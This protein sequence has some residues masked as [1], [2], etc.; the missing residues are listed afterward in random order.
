VAHR[1]FE[2]DG[3]L[4]G[5]RTDSVEFA[6]W[7]EQSLPAKLVHDEI[8]NPN[9][10]AL[11]G[12][13]GRLGKWLHVLYRDSTVLVRTTDANELV[14]V[15]AGD[16][17]ALT[18]WRRRDAVYVQAAVVS[19]GG[20][21][22]LFPEEFIGLL[23]TARRRIRSGGIPLPV[24]RH[25]AVDLD[26]AEVGL[27]SRPLEIAEHAV[28]ELACEVG[29][30]PMAWPRVATL[31]RATPDLVCVKG[32]G[33][34]ERAQPV[35]RGSALYALASNAVNLDEVRGAGLEAL[36]RLVERAACWALPALSA[37]RVADGV[38]DLLQT[39]AADRAANG[40]YRR[41][42]MVSTS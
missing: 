28:A 40:R 29:S 4:F 22:A 17:A 37:Q 35:S 2:L 38:S 24:S 18:Y 34:S 26:T 36:R 7:L 30:E 21:D 12:G 42:R 23:E 13:R 41:E 11:V 3:I 19:A 16:L 15:L 25:V 9:Y 8:A 6:R 33:D 27:P 10:S 31:Q 5:I 14:A 1:S 39:V 32:S 20:V